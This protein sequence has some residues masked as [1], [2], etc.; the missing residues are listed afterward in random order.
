MLSQLSLKMCILWDNM[1]S[2]KNIINNE[3][4]NEDRNI[5]KHTLM[6]EFESLLKTAMQIIEQSKNNPNDYITNLEAWLAD[7]KKKWYVFSIVF[8]LVAF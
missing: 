7:C 8:T 6:N 5:L 4:E 2:K 3:I 1:Q